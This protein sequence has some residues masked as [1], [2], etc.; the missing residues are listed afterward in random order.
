M[1]LD[2]EHETRDW[3]KSW[4]VSKYGKGYKFVDE[5]KYKFFHRYVLKEL[6]DS[7]R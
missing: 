4:T 7:Q 1:E 2:E 6:L 3:E 5:G